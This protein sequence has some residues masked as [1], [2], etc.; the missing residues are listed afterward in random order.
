MT[1]SLNLVILKDI[2]A[3]KFIPHG[4]NIDI[5]RCIV[6]YKTLRYSQRRLGGTRII[7]IA[8][9]LWQ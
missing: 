7:N 6:I 4:C 3:N 1:L 5:W 2:Y 8:Q 9:I